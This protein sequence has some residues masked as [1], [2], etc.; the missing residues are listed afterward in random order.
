MNLESL[1]ARA[2]LLRKI[3]DYF[4]EAKVLEADVPALAAYSVTDVNLRAL[5]THWQAKTLYLQTSPEFYL[6]RLLAAGFG[7]LYYLGKAYR[8]D[9]SAA[10]HQPEFTMLEWYRLGFDDNLLINDVKALLNHVGLAEP[11]EVCDYRDVFFAK[12]GLDPHSACD[13]SLQQY[14]QGRYELNWDDAPRSTW[15]ELVF[16]FDIE[17]TLQ[18][19]TIV[20]NFPRCQAALAKVSKDEAGEL[21]AKRFEFYWQGLE[22][23]NGYWELTDAKE[24]RQRFMDDNRTRREQGL[25]E[26]KPDPDF[27]AAIEKGLPE[28][29]GIALGVD[30]LLMCLLGKKHIRDVLAFTH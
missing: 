9:D 26:I 16:S 22:I 25:P 28:C 2:Q 10:R 20:K 21:V 15:L 11:L 23:A 14:C 19:P 18:S 17:P 7:E 24:Q 29:A 3:R 8:N 6:K 1:R 27:L 13:Q 30:R 12:T 5:E 4:A